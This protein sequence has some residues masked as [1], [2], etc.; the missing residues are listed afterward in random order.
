[1]LEERQ[2]FRWLERRFEELIP[3]EE[4][5]STQQAVERERSHYNVARNASLDQGRYL[6]MSGTVPT[7]A[8]GYV[9]K[10]ALLARG[11]TSSSTSAPSFASTSV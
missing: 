3:K 4:L 10:D 8:R 9:D 5:Q 6:D 2:T 7:G 1:M 11:A